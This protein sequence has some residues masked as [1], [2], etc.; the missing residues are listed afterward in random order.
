MEV[1]INY[2]SRAKGSRDP[3][4]VDIIYLD[5]SN[6]MHREAAIKVKEKFEGTA[7]DINFDKT[8]KFGPI[9][10]SNIY[11]LN[12]LTQELNKLFTDTPYTTITPKYA[13]H[14][15]VNGVFGP[16]DEALHNLNLIMGLVWFPGN[17]SYTK[18]SASLLEEI[19]SLNNNLKDDEPIVICGSLDVIKNSRYEHG[20]ELHCTPQ[21]KPFNITLLE[22]KTTQFKMGDNTLIYIGFPHKVT[23]SPP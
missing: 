8:K 18:I 2:P 4:L 15:I 22:K 12:A 19:K 23:S 1:S 17:K 11:S 20:L 5:Y 10:G 7:A 14:G 6:K 9:H 16:K 13:H 21:T 3:D